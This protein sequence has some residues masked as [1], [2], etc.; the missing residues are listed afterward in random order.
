MWFR[1]E[2]TIFRPP[3][4][5]FTMTPA[6]DGPLRLSNRMLP[7]GEPVVVTS[8]APVE[9]P[10]WL[11]SRTVVIALVLLGIGLRVV[12][13]VQ[14]RNLWIDEAMLGLNLVER[15]H[16]QLLTPLD[17]NQAAPVGF[18]LAVKTTMTAFGTSEWAMRLFPFLGSVLGLIGFAWVARR[19]LPPAA[20]T[21]GLALFAIAPHLV[22]YS[23]ECKQYATDAALAVGM[24][25]AGLSLLQGAG[26]FRRWAVLAGV[27][28]LAVW[29]SHPVAF[30][31]GG[32]GGAL[33]LD[34]LARKDRTRVFACLATIGCWLVSFGLCYFLFVAQLGNNQ[35][36]L[37]YW[38]GHF[39]PLPPKELG[40]LAWLAD[41]FFGPIGYPGGLGGSEV[42]AGG[43]AAVLFIVGVAGF[44]RER[45]PLAVAL[46][47]PALLALLASG[48]HK[49]P[50]AG[51]L[52]LF[53]VP[54]LLLG[55][56]R[57]AWAVA[58]ALRPTQPFA[59]VVLL[60]VLLA[61]PMLETYQQLRRP[62]RYEQLTEVLTDLRAR[63]RPGDKVYVYYGAIPA[64]TFYTRDNPFPADVT[65]G[66]EHRDGRTGY[67]DELRKFAGQPRVWVVFS[68]RHQAE[69]SLLRSYAEG[70]GECREEIQRPGATAFRYDFRG[71]KVPE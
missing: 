31:L 7:L 66:T 20:A 11:T 21:L 29:F 44:W 27:G 41:H 47:V 68:H 35:F 57:G 59:A 8:P 25:A 2:V 61:A 53:L 60:G 37:D 18:L 71:P 55:V 69:E 30:V 52:L 64:F 45:W 17:W 28:A 54:L 16:G 42:K 49:Y 6:T 39:L 62:P 43:I 14:N 26:G 46:V 65:L 10:N 22:D 24:F 15:S 4:E 9:Q 67:R 23:A 33:F 1:A 12:P 50:F 36:L 13:M 32:V 40:D 56:A 5:D 19:M 63:V 58:C 70:L 34:A 51:R 48:V 3:Q 38:A